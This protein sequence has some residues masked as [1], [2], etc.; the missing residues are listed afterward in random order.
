MAD[1]PEK[2]MPFTAHLAELRR[3]LIISF[4]AVG[5]GF[6][7]AYAFSGELLEWLVRPLIKALPPGNKLVFTA[8]PEAFF[9]Y[10]KVSLIAGIVVASPVIFYQLWMFI[11][12]GL[13]HKEKRLVLPFVFISTALFVGGALFGYYVVFPVGF[14]FLVGFSTEN[15]KALP[16]I[17]MYL[18]FSLKLLLGFG[19]VFEFPVLAYFLGKA[20][21]INAKMMANNRRVAILLIF[22]VA[23][24]V[25]PPDIVSQILLAI[26]LYI[27]YEG[28]ILIVRIIGRKREKAL[29]EQ[30]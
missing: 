30:S 29:T 14:K 10:L 13:Y 3:C 2:T 15:I 17:Q 24:V 9:I 21:I 19:L 4:A 20:G 6:L 12:P 5:V 22:I 25:T 28:S 23:A 16:S 1:T 26:P 18:T 8:L 7:A 11:A 27:L